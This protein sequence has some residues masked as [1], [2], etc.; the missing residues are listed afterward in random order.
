MHGRPGPKLSMSEGIRHSQSCVPFRPP[1][2]D[3][4]QI[5][6]HLNSNGFDFGSFLRVLRKTKTTPSSAFVPS[7]KLSLRPSRLNREMMRR[8]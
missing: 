8:Q 2:T 5:E 7:L 1:A 3:L 6:D 4:S